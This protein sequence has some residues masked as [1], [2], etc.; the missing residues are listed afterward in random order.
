MCWKS[1]RALQVEGLELGCG[2]GTNSRRGG[3]S[4]LSK[5]RHVNQGWNQQALSNSC[6]WRIPTCLTCLSQPHLPKAG[7]DL[8]SDQGQQW[9]SCFSFPAVHPLTHL[10]I[11]VL[12][13]SSKLYSFALVALKITSNVRLSRGRIIPNPSLGW[14]STNFKMAG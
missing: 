9:D 10:L 4:H 14:T 2:T 12:Q 8:I 6:N 13:V 1:S 11:S 3:K 7:R 5:D